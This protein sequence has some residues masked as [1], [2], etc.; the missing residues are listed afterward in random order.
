MIEVRRYEEEEWNGNILPL[1]KKGT[2][3]ERKDLND[4]GF[5]IIYELFDTVIED[6]DGKLYKCNAWG[7]PSGNPYVNVFEYVK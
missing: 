1:I 2:L 7:P 5:L 6:T 4:G 3:K